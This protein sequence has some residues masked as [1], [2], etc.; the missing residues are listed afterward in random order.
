MRLAPVGGLAN[1]KT[2][3]MM[4][5]PRHCPGWESLKTLKSFECRCPECGK[6][7]EIFSD[8]VD[9]TRVCPGCRKG[10]DFSKCTLRASGGKNDP[11]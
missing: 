3:G 4:N 6:E 5:T 8:E 9:K 7:I 10:I 1:G 11:R 2:E